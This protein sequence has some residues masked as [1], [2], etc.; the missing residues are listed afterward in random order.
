MF[1]AYNYFPLLYTRPS[2]I[3]AIAN[4]PEE[5]KNKFLPILFCRPWLNSKSLNNL[6]VKIDEAFKG[7]R[8]VIELD[9]SKFEPSSS[10]PAYQEFARLFSPVNGFENYYGKVAELAFAIPSLRFSRDME[11][12]RLQIEKVKELGRGL[13]FIIR[14][15]E[16]WD[17]PKVFNYL[18]ASE[19]D[20]SL[21]IDF[22]WGRDLLLFEAWAQSII[23]SAISIYPELEI[24]VIGSSFPESFS[25]IS[26]VGRVKIIERELFERL[27]SKNNMANLYYGDW[28]SSRPPKE[29]T[30]MTNVPRIDYPTNTEWLCFRKT[31]DEDYKKIAKRVVSFENWNN[32]LAVWGT[33]AIQWTADGDPGGINT[34]TKN[35][36][37]RLNIHI[38][39][40][41]NSGGEIPT[42]TKLEPY[43]D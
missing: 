38:Q 26:S 16:S 8:F 10:K 34:P 9:Y 17:Y 19:I 5:T 36:A 6:W 25:N 14:R 39:L 13:V 37:V 4:L 33:R 32:G 23:D 30:P 1:D 43:Q 21:V 29:S 28:A 20:F 24:A 3:A 40:Q 18:R 11:N 22:E 27:K 2:E 31:G 7:R 12:I 41:A 15:S 35:A 42:D